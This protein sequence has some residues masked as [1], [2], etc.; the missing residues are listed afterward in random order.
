MDVDEVF[1]PQCL[2]DLVLRLWLVFLP[3]GSTQQMF[4]C[5]PKESEGNHKDL[6]FVLVRTL[7]DEEI[8]QCKTAFG[9]LRLLSCPLGGPK[10]QF[11]VGLS[12]GSFQ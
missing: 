1:V 7:R 9:P 12:N 2:T 11:G 8:V 4:I 10:D 5:F 3:K 6:S